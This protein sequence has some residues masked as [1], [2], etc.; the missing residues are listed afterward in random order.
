[1]FPCDLVLLTKLIRWPFVYRSKRQLLNP[2]RWPIYVI[3][4]VL[5]LLNYPVILSHRRSPTVSSKTNPPYLAESVVSLNESI[6]YRSQHTAK[7]A[8]TWYPPIDSVN[9]AS[10][11]KLLVYT[12][13][14]QDINKRGNHITITR[15]AT[16]SPPKPHL[17][18]VQYFW[19]LA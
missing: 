12:E 4:S 8:Q 6:S 13:L 11:G 3:N 9:V 19:P 1:M 15:R 10:C 18:M 2:S 5:I 16:R 17:L 14:M 7:Q